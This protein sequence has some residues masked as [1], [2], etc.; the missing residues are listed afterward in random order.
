MYN[1][2]ILYIYQ[3]INR[4]HIIVEKLKN[5]LHKYAAHHAKTT[6]IISIPKCQQI[7]DKYLMMP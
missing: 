6:H 7:L 5:V 3:Y 4:K 1:V 2:C